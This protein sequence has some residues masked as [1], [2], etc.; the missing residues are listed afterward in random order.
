[1]SFD[2]FDYENLINKK[3]KLNSKNPINY[4]KAVLLIIKVLIA[5]IIIIIIG[6]S[7]IFTTNNL[8]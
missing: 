3:K 8:D 5:T 7:F 2:I 1:M 6:V 4:G